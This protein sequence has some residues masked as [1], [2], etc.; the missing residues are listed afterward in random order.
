MPKAIITFK[1]NK[2]EESG[3]TILYPINSVSFNPINERWFMTA[4]ADG[5]IHF[6]DY[7]ARNKIKTLNYAGNPVCSATVNQ[8]GDMI[9]YGLGNDWHLGQEGVNKWQTKVGVHQVT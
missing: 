7:E 9:A 5:V 8:K 4:G 2:Q 1:S 3:N 6:W